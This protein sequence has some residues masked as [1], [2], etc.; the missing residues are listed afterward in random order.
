MIPKPTIEW[1]EPPLFKS[2]Q[3]KSATNSVR[4]SIRI[5]VL[6]AVMGGCCLAWYFGKENS[7]DKHASLPAM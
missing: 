7:P 3:G 1:Q 2:F 6:V 4:L 5:F